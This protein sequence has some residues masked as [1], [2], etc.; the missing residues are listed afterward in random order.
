MGSCDNLPCLLDDKHRCF[1]RNNRAQI[2]GHGD[3]VTAL[4]CN[5][6]QGN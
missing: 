2:L 4:P 6:G 5:A 3:Y 1:W